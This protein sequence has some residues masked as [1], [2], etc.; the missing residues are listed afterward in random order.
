MA[1]A[2]TPQ[3]KSAI[4]QFCSFTNADRNTAIRVSLCSLHTVEMISRIVDEGMGMGGLLQSE[5]F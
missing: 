2:Y 4:A 5:G 3:Q 1:P